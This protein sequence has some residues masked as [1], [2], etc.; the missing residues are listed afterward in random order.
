MGWGLWSR[1][2][3]MGSRGSDLGALGFGLGMKIK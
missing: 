3:C 1:R 2:Y